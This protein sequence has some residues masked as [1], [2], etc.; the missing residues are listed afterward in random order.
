M[1]R[2]V[3]M[4]NGANEEWWEFCSSRRAAVVF[5]GKLF[6]KVERVVPS[7]PEKQNDFAF[8]SE[9]FNYPVRLRFNQD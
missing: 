8:S 1:I 6:V 3:S 5:L 7:P 4:A 2:E 9:R